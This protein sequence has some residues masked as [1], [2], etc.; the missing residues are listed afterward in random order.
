M[1]LYSLQSLTVKESSTASL[2]PGLTR[3][4]RQAESGPSAGERFDNQTMQRLLRSRPRPAGG[5]PLAVN[6]QTPTQSGGLDEKFM[7]GGEPALAQQAA[8]KD[9]DLGEKTPQSSN[10]PVVDRVE[11]VTTENGAV[12]GFKEK[13]DLCNA[14]MNHPGPFNDIWS[15]GAV[16]NVLQVQFHLSQGDP[17]DL[18]AHRVV[19]RTSTGRGQATPPKVGDDG[20]PP[21]EYQFTKEKL[22]V[23]DAPGWCRTLKEEDFPVTYSADFT[24]YAYDPL[25]YHVVASISYHVEIAKTHYSQADPVNTATVTA[26]NTGGALPSPVK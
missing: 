8:E 3:R 16:A 18:R 15:Q 20:P 21:W 10:H 14:S 7:Q 5:G 2:P 25:D 1:G 23:G 22:V 17:T 11:L 13:E 6:D 19:N 9:I 12:G 26:V 4:P 24:V